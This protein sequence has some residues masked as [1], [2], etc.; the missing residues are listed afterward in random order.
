MC[1]GT[2][3]AGERRLDVQVRLTG[4]P[5][6]DRQALL[7]AEVARKL[8][9]ETDREFA[10]VVYTAMFPVPA[11]GE[12]L[13]PGL[14]PLRRDA[15]R[16]APRPAAL[17]HGRSG[18]ASPPGWS[19]RSI[20]GTRPT[21]IYKRKNQLNV[22][23]TPTDATGTTAGVR[24]HRHHPQQPRRGSSTAR[25][26]RRGW[27]SAPTHGMTAVRAVLQGRRAGL[28]RPPDRPRLP[29]PPGMHV[30]LHAGQHHDL[31]SHRPADRRWVDPELEMDRS[32][33]SSKAAARS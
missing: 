21:G 8:Q 7:E 1:S 2:Y 3:T 12:P 6:E 13:Q 26:R 33:A 25:R 22:E 5:A 18:G 30:E 14:E 16:S 19:R 27:P 29:A 4:V 32:P 28:H 24:V 17:L 31:P 20:H 10:E 23:G 11:D 15:L 9:G